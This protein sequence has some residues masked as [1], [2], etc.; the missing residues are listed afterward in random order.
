[1]NRHGFVRRIR[2][3]KSAQLASES[4]IASR[5]RCQLLEHI[6]VLRFVAEAV[7]NTAS[8]FESVLNDLVASVVNAR[9]LVFAE[10][11]GELLFTELL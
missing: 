3:L 6:A 2:I 10:N 1:M 8:V 7:R 9:L 5:K 4:L 11:F